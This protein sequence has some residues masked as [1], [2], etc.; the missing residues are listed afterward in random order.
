MSKIAIAISLVVA[1]LAGAFAQV[2][3][4]RTAGGNSTASNDEVS[5]VFVGDLML[6]RYV[7]STLAARGYDTPF[8]GVRSLLQPADLAVGNLESPLVRR[9]SIRV[10]PPSPN[11]LNLT[12]DD[13]AAPALSRA[14]FDLLSLSNNHALDSGAFGL[15]STVN[16]LRASSL[17]PFGLADK[18]GGQLP[19]IRDVRGVKV[20]FLGYTTILN[21]ITNDMRSNGTL[22][23]GVGYVNP[24]SKADKD[25]FAQQIASARA[26]ADVVVVFMHWGNEY[27]T[28]PDS[29]VVDLGKLAARSGADLVVGAH[30]HVAQGMKV[31]LEGTGGRST[32]VAYSLGNALFDQM[33]RMETRQG[34]ALSVRADRHGVK[35]ARLVPLEITAGSYK[36]RVADD[37]SGQPT[38]KRAALSTPP[39]LQWRAIWDANQPQPG[40]A[41]GYRRAAQ[42]QERASV[43]ELGLGAPTR[44]ELL[45]GLLTVQSGDGKGNWKTVWQTE[46]TWRVTGY[47]VGDANADG[48]PDLVYS[49]WKKRLTWERPEDGG[50]QVDMEGGDFLPHI[51]IN[52]WRDGAL[53][54]LWHGSPRP[55]PILDLAVVPLGPAGK[56][57][58]GVFDSVDPAQE[59]PPGK[60]NLWHW[61]GSFGFEL[62]K[63]LPGTY[64]TTWG[65]GKVLLLK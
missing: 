46:P 32:V 5:L 65:E 8:E 28:Q 17:V 36:M 18:Q 39:D 54:P 43:E 51:Y 1:L 61:T 63:S 49:L 4:A 30:P 26:K 20:A 55:S 23:P 29:W 22:R 62:L 58:L 11:Q 47:T 35:S 57:T 14:G 44:I 13:R 38:A 24:T 31:E 25:L 41:I 19:V 60:V 56:P 45:N 6:G 52:S 42:S 9:G 27:K 12:G 33:A 64:S 50:L 2:G 53:M 7:G 21:I 48:K 3:G 59:Q 37:A 16:A 40:V 10:P 15:Q 34:L